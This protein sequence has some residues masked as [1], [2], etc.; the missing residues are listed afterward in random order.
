MDDPRVRIRHL[1]EME[2]P[3]YLEKNL[4]TWG[5]LEVNF[6]EKH[7]GKKFREAVQDEDWVKYLVHRNGEMTRG[8]KV[9][10]NYVEAY[11]KEKERKK[12][13]SC[14]T[15]TKDEASQAEALEPVSLH[16][17]KPQDATTSCMT[18]TS[19]DP[20]ISE[21]RD[22]MVQLLQEHRDLANKMRD[23]EKTLQQVSLQHT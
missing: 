1:L 19:R 14:S 18:H 2:E 8:Q 21:I 17:V 12:G 22:M 23:L 5:K 6:G 13:V 7:K 9:F 16:T 4:V 11:L 20:M 10:M 3:D 15:D